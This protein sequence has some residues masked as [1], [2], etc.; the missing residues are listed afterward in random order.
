[1]NAV[2]TVNERTQMA[3][4]QRLTAFT[5]RSTSVNGPASCSLVV[6]VHDA[7]TSVHGTVHGPLIGKCHQ[8]SQIPSG[9][10]AVHAVHEGLAKD[11]HHDVS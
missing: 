5:P 8:I 4:Y 1:M 11:T 9:V 3:C 10:H 2:N 7:V 6:T